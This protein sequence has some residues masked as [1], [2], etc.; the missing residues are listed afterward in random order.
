MIKRIFGR[1]L[2]IYRKANPLAYARGIGVKI[3]E[4]TKLI[5]N[6][7]WGSE[8]YLIS[9]GN[10]TLISGG[11]TF[12]THD[13]SVRVFKNKGK[14]EEL[15]KYGKIEIGDNCFI[16]MGSTLMLNVKIGNNS[17]VAAKSV[18]TKSIPENEVWGGIP[19]KKIMTLE[20][21]EGKM[22][23]TC[24]KSSKEAMHNN[25]KQEIIRIADELWLSHNR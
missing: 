13:F 22:V 21:Y 19:A 20:E 15:Y 24:G 4:G 18:V 3:G 17:I 16:G 10:N 7:S 14:H 5:D 11:V 6:P 12:I 23:L 2:T 9:I 25:R 1:I 8:P